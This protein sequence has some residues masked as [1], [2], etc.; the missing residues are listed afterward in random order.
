MSLWLHRLI[1]C[2]S[3]AGIATTAWAQTNQG[4]GEQIR[5]LPETDRQKIVT[6]YAIGSGLVY[7]KFIK[8]DHPPRF[9]LSCPGQGCDLHLLG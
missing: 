6:A 9:F 3:A 4:I 1:A 5:R 8:F 2:F 7:G